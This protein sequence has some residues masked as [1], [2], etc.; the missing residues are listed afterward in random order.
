MGGMVPTIEAAQ[1]AEEVATRIPAV[2]GILSLTWVVGLPWT[3]PYDLE[4][5]RRA[6][7]P[8][9]GAVVY[10]GLTDR[11]VGGAGRVSQN[12]LD[13]R[14]R[15]LSHLVIQVKEPKTGRRLGDKRP[16]LTARE[17]VIPVSAIEA[18][19][20]DSV[21]LMEGEEINWYPVFHPDMYPLATQDWQPPFPYKKGRL[22]W[23]CL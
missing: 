4:P 7:Q 1:A 9:M 2:R 20:R 19:N 17:R 12:I 3:N 11:Q 21:W 15:L 16:E 6:F 22:R 23:S 14:N 5:A 13:P 10:D 18:V 8:G